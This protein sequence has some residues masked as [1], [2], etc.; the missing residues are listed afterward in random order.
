LDFIFRYLIGDK[1][2]DDPFIL[3]IYWWKYA[4][5][6]LIQ[7]KLVE[8]FP[9]LI[10][11][12]QNDF[13]VYG[14]LDQFLFKES[15]NLILQ[16]LCDDKPWKQDMDVILSINNCR[17]N[18]SKNF[19]NLHLLLLCNDLLNINSVPLEKIKEIIYLGKS[20]KK[21]EFIT[22]EIIN[23]VF[24]NLDNKN[25]IIPI[26]SFITRSLKLISLESK[27]RLILY[28]NIFSQYSFKLMNNGIIEKIFNNEIQQNEQIFF[29]LIENP[30][31]ALQLA[32]RLKTI[33]DN[34]NDINSNMA[35]FCCEII[36]SIFNKFELNELVPYFKNSIES[37]M[38]QENL[39]LQQI[40][41]IAFLK[42]FISKYWKNYFQK[43][44]LL[45]K[46]LINEINNILKISSHLFIQ[47][48]Q[49]YFI[50]D[51]YKQSSFNIKQF[52]MLKK[53]FLCF[54]NKSFIEIEINTNM[55][56]NLLPKLWKPVRKVDFKD[57]YT[58]HIANLNEYPFLSV[59][60]KHYNSLKLIK[61]LYPIIR[62]MKILNSKLEY[63]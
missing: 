34:I 33:N 51:L 38:K 47:S 42:E 60:F 7:L 61:Y 2:V 5:E 4:T 6:I 36:Q 31:V 39:P 44:N 40:T 14:K 9:D 22:T 1:F 32:I 20:A 45:S 30:E 53:E 18:D 10:T 43:E 63:H 8:T 56:M 55:E 16:N 25:D 58:F 12:A 3:H 19:S 46:S 57:L 28:K 26:T 11:K 21:Q 35:E 24:S 17:I 27:I 15:I 41:S 13:I 50:L 29:I 37:L 48:M 62:F 54:E 23:L 52:E 59:F 49:T